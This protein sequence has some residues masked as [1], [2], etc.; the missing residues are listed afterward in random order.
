MVRK[1]FTIIAYDITDDKMR[2]NVSKLL[3][4]VGTRRNKSVF[5][6]MISESQLKKIQLELPKLID[7]STD[8]VLIYRV[9]L[10]CYVKSETIGKNTLSI[11]S[12]IMIV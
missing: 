4:S 5:E 9:C 8:T 2:N 10:D 1:K 7:T 12:T 11:G 6:C 3:E